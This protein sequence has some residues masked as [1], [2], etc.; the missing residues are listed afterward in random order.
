MSQTED[1]WIQLY[2]GKPKNKYFLS[3]PRKKS[4]TIFA[5]RFNHRYLIRFWISPF[6]VLRWVNRFLPLDE[7]ELFNFV[8]I[9][10]LPKTNGS[11]ALPFVFFV[12]FVYWISQQVIIWFCWLFARIQTSLLKTFPTA[13]NW[14]STKFRLNY[15]KEKQ[16]C[17]L[18]FCKFVRNKTSMCLFLLCFGKPWTSK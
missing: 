6:I 2:E 14:E 10:S 15:V 7:A 12:L 9:L 16:N 4:W 5:Q 8:S 11:L 13:P 1:S 18:L 3:H 17:M